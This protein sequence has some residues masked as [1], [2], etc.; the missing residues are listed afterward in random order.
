MK[1]DENLVNKRKKRVYTK[2]YRHIFYSSGISDDD[3]F[4]SSI[5]TLRASPPEADKPEASICCVI[6]GSQ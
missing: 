1:I 4:F 5:F 6:K 3:L 2:S